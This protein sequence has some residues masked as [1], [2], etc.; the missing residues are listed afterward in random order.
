AFAA[1]RAGLLR[2]VHGVSILRELTPRTMD[3][4]C[5]Y[6][7]RFSSR[8]VTAGLQ[9]QGVDAVWVDAADFMLTDGNF[10][11]AIPLMESVRANLARVVVPLLERSQV[12][13]TQGFIGVTADGAYTTMGR[14]SSDYSASII[15]AAL[16][17]DRVQIWTDVDG[18]LTADPR[19]VTDVRKVR[20]MS[21]DEAFELSYFGAKVLHPRTMLPLLERNIPV[22]VRNSRREEGTGTL[23]VREGARPGDAPSVKSIAYAADV[24]V[25]CVAPRHR[26]NQYHFWEGIFGVLSSSGIDVRSVATSEF[27]IAF[28]VTGQ[29]DRDGVARRLNE[30]GNVEIFPEQASLCIVGS[31]LRQ[32][33]ELAGRVFGALTGTAT[34]LITYGAS[35]FSM[36]LVVPR[37]QLEQSLAR[38]HAEFFGDSSR[39]EEFDVPLN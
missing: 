37:S 2:L 26:S 1:Y 3:A 30:F 35:G 13:V 9:E 19:K 39:G 5:S 16:D 15:G 4:F 22:E 18:L 11:R 24:T 6:G 17:A 29:F 10:G 7:E 38:L 8:L 21:F 34:S 27:R 25:V 33:P 32:S 12:P 36:T 28:T 20:R 23:I 31:G 14:E